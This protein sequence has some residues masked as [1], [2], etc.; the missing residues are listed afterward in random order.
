V[1]TTQHPIHGHQHL[2]NRDGVWDAHRSAF[3]ANHPNGNA[4][5][6]SR[7]TESGPRNTN[8]LGHQSPPGQSNH[9]LCE[10]RG[11]GPAGTT[12]HPYKV[13][14][15]GPKVF[16]IEVESSQWTSLNHTPEQQ[17]ETR[18]AR[19]RGGSAWPTPGRSS[20]PNTSNISKGPI[21]R[22]SSNYKCKTV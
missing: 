15:K 4:G 20:G 11:Q 3:A 2:G 10:E 5:G 16:H 12:L 21:A 14:R 6:R 13:I 1:G 8:P 22:A 9:G 17:Q 7:A 18:R 19:P